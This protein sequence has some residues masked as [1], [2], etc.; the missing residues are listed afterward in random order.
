MANIQVEIGFDITGNRIG[1]N[2]RTFEVVVPG[3]FGD[4]VNV[5]ADVPVTV[6]EAVTF[7]PHL[8]DWFISETQRQL[9]TLSEHFPADVDRLR[10]ELK[11]VK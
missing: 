10:T 2:L 7:Q 3:E 9:D 1:W 4:F 8:R 6:N 5:L 11:A